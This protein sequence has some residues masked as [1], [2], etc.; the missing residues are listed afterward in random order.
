MTKDI[1]EKLTQRWVDAW[2][3]GDKPFD[4]ELFR[5]LFSPNRIEVF[6]NVQGDVIVLH[7]AE[8]YLTT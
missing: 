6:D 2:N 8:E 1:I 3:I 5:P 4:A 7:S